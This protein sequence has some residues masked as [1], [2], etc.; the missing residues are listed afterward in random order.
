MGDVIGDVLEDSLCPSL[1]K[2]KVIRKILS[3]WKRSVV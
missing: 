1:Q 3:F 2:G